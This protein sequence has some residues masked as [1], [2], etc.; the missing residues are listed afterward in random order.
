[1]PTFRSASSPELDV[2]V[3][4]RHGIVDDRSIAAG[5]DVWNSLP[6]GV[7]SVFQER[8]DTL[9]FGFLVN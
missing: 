9:L 7:I 2:P 6:P 1:M 8:L 4:V 3:I 5:V